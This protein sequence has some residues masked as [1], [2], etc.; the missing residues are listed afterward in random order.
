MTDNEKKRRTDLLEANRQRE[1]E[2]DETSSTTGAAQREDKEGAPLTVP[3]PLTDEQYQEILRPVL[4]RYGMQR[5][6]NGD[7]ITLNPSDYRAII[8]RSV[9]FGLAKAA[10]AAPVQTAVPN[11]WRTTMANLA[12]IVRVQNGNLH[13]D[14]NEILAQA[15]KCL[16]VQ[17]EQA[18]AEPVAYLKF[19]AAQRYMGDGNIDHDEGLEVCRKDDIGIDGV[20]AFPVYA[21]PVSA[22]PAQA[23]QVEAVRAAAV[24]HALASA[25]AR[26][27]Q[28]A[29]VYSF[30]YMQDEAEDEEDCVCGPKQHA[31][32]KEVFAAIKEVERCIALATKEAA[33]QV[34]AA[35]DVRAKALEEAESAIE[36]VIQD[37]EFDVEER[38]GAYQCRAAIRA[39]ATPS[40]TPSNDTS[41]LG[42]TGGAK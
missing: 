24:P 31:E 5:F 40:T 11:E 6:L 29:K 22:L 33:A 25:Q 10:P 8:D 23:E 20:A 17:A 4:S 35:E 42:D 21:A 36:G 1:L 37:L 14:T 30:N 9:E 7:E 18:Q 27:L 12:A 26:L 41:A 28:A 13:A 38:S 34:P 16:A 19:W 15:E 2:P 32:A 3:A 39:L